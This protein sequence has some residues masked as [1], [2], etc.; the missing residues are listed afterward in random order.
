MLH[1]SLCIYLEGSDGG[2]GWGGDIDIDPSNLKDK[3]RKILFSILFFSTHKVFFSQ[4][5]RSISHIV[6]IVIII[7]IIIIIR[8]LSLRLNS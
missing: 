7:I 2:N 8:H 5:I 3:V 1:N 6:V 4:H